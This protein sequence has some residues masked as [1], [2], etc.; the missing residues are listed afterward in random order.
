M[1]NLGTT[2]QET[3]KT[4]KFWQLMMARRMVS[5][6]GFYVK[7][8]IPKVWTTSKGHWF[9]PHIAF[10]EQIEGGGGGR[11]LEANISSTVVVENRETLKL[12]IGGLKGQWPC[13]LIFRDFQQTPVY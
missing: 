4:A 9:W 10:Q 3:Y 12:A 5:F 2:S 1:F 6:Y 8:F 13:C 7:P 11:E